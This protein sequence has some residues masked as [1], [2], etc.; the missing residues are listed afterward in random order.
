VTRTVM[1]PRRPQILVL[2]AA[3][4]TG[5]YSQDSRTQILRRG[6]SPGRSEPRLVSAAIAGV[7]GAAAPR[8]GPRHGNAQGA[9]ARAGAEAERVGAAALPVAKSNRAS[10]SISLLSR[11]RSVYDVRSPSPSRTVT[12]TRAVTGPSAPGRATPAG[13]AAARAVTVPRRCGGPSPSESGSDLKSVP[14]TISESPGPA[15]PCQC[16]ISRCC[17]SRSPVGHGVSPS[18]S[19]HGRRAE[20]FG[21]APAASPGGAPSPWNGLNAT[22]LQQPLRPILHGPKSVRHGAPTLCGGAGGRAGGRACESDD[23]ASERRFERGRERER[24]RERE[25]S[26]RGPGAPARSCPRP[27]H[28]PQ[29]ANSGCAHGRN[30]LA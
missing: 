23:D 26:L 22:S 18:F 9:R 24:E 10:G 13:F 30:S 19:V 25:G 6:R 4:P 1:P 16:P 27:N 28:S 21:P 14:L 7:A 20:P 2:R 3:G 12:V 8:A 17:P 15:S 5:R 11:R 29:R